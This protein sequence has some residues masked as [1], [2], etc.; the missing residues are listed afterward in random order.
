MVATIVMLYSPSNRRESVPGDV[1]RCVPR[2]G[3]TSKH[4]GH[5][6]TRGHECVGRHRGAWHINRPNRPKSAKSAKSAKVGQIG[7]HSGAGHGADNLTRRSG[8]NTHTD[9]SGATHTHIHTH[10]CLNC[11]RK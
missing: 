7:Q 3:T 11:R 2:T 9:D 10:R 6:R 4:R 5:L 8:T 1:H